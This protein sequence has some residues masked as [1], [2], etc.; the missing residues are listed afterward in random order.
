MPAYFEPLGDDRYRPT[1]EAEGAWNPG[2][3]HFSPLGGLVVHAIDK[4][5]A[6]RAPGGPDTKLLGRISFDILGFLAD[7]VCTVSVR[8]TRPGRTIELV[9]A[10]VVIGDRPAV[11]ARAW[12]I[13]A[14]DTAIVRGGE[15]DP[16]PSPETVE[17]QTLSHT[18]SGGFVASLDVREVA[19]RSPGRGTV[20]L[21]TDAQLVEGEQVSP[22]ASFI[23]LVD[24]ANGIAAR[25]P[26]SA[27]MFPNVDLT[28]HL[29]RQ[30]QGSWV[31]LD[32]SV[33][34]G[35]SGLGLTSSVLHDA[36]GAVGRAEQ[37]LTVRPVP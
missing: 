14:S 26:G 23:A 30:P 2:E 20:W 1:A 9:E 25:E 5:R 12:F 19:P 32:T 18:W 24:T 31:G 36:H 8:T 17:P 13:G 6:E 27:W 35:A 7:D 16:I 21:N 29:F 22:A 33:V 37:L 11:L 4:H 15:P 10:T 3:I 28:V 34:F